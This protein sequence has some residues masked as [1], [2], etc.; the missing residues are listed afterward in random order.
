LFYWH[1][2]HILIDFITRKQKGEKGKMILPAI[3]IKEPWAGMI[4]SGKKTLEIRT[5]KTPHRG[6]IILCASASPTSDI[7]GKAFALADLVDIRPMTPEDK[8]A[9]G[10]V[11]LPDTWAWELRNVRPFKPFP[12]KGR[13]GLFKIDTK[14]KSPI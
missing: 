4:K 5:W 7:S 6:K 10:G 11:Y 9:A 8:P 1:W 13:L 14:T 3:S 12:V 2:H